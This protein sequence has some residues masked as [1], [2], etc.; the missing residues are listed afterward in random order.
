M[1]GSMENCSSECKPQQGEMG[2]CWGTRF[3]P[4]LPAPPPPGQVRLSQGAAAPFVHLQLGTQDSSGRRLAL[5]RSSVH[6]LWAMGL[7]QSLGWHRDLWQ[8]LHA[9][10]V[11]LLPARLT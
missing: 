9:W 11:A 2:D 5:G 7:T 3:L 1:N 4:G 8:I 10:R 6:G